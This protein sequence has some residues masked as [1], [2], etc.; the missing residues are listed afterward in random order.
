M[1]AEIWT[2]AFFERWHIQRQEHHSLDLSLQ[3]ISLEHEGHFLHLSSINIYLEWCHTSPPHYRDSYG[4]V[5][6]QRA[7]SWHWEGAVGLVVALKLCGCMQRVQAG[8][9][10]GVEGSWLCTSTPL[11]LDPN[12]GNN[13]TCQTF[14]PQSTTLKSK[15]DHCLDWAR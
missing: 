4:P 9:G 5:L 14:R 6:G 8:A 3:W 7:Q 1:E 15:W 12:T 10:R 13:N 2:T 11:C